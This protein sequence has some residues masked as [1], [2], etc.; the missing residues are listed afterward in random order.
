MSA[1]LGKVRL[2]AKFI[3]AG[4]FAPG[5]IT[6]GFISKKQKEQWEE[7]EME[8]KDQ[9]SRQ[10]STGFTEIGILFTLEVSRV[11]D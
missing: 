10:A 6:I 8:E 4:G 1:Q 5:H 9:E 3:E 11:K 7:R 2:N